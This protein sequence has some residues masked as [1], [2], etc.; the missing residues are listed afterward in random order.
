MLF[1]FVLFCGFFCFVFAFSLESSADGLN[2]RC[3]GITIDIISGL[4]LYEIISMGR[5]CITVSIG[6]WQVMVLKHL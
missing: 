5:Y 3:K 1:F 6:Y 2:F 4:L